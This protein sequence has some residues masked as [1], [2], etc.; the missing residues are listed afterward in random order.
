MRRF[1][2]QK[3]T[4][5]THKRIFDR[6]GPTAGIKIN[7]YLCGKTALAAQVTRPLPHFTVKILIYVLYRVS[8]KRL[9]CFTMIACN[10]KVRDQYI[11]TS[12]DFYELQLLKKFVGQF[13]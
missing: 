6:T 3:R 4:L 13:K 5:M 12:S 8:S 11:L 9:L 7:F 2:I 1:L 10:F